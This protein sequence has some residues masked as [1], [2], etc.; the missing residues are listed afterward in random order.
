MPRTLAASGAFAPASRAAVLS[1]T[2]LAASAPGLI[3]PLAAL[4]LLCAALYAGAPAHASPGGISGASGE[5]GD[6]SGCHSGSTYNYSGSLSSSTTMLPSDSI[7][8][9]FSLNRNSGSSAPN[10]GFNASATSG[11]FTAGTGSHVLVAGEVTH[12]APKATSGGNVSWSFDYNSPATVGTVTLYACGNPVVVDSNT[13]NDGPPGCTTRNITVNGTPNAVND[14]GITVAKNSSSNTLSPLSNDTSGPSGNEGGD[15]ITI[16]STG[17]SASSGTVSRINA[18]TQLSYTPE[19]DFTGAVTINYQIVDS[20]GATDSATLSLT[21]NNNAPVADND[22]TYNGTED[23]TLNVSAGSGVLVGDTDAN[24]DSLQAYVLAVPSNGNLTLNTN[25]SFSY[26]PDANTNGADSFTYRAWDGT[27]YSAAAT[28]NISIAAVNDNPVANNDSYSTDEDVPVSGNVRTNDTDAETPTG[29]LTVEKLS[30]PAHGTLTSWTPSTG[31]F[32]YT[33]ASLY[34]GPD[35]FTYRVYDGA[36]YSGTATVNISVASVNNAPVAVANSYST[37]EDTTLNVTTVGTLGNG[38]LANDTDA[39]SPSLTAS[40][41][42]NVSYGSLTLNSNGTFSYTP[43]L[44]YNGPDSFTYRAYDGFD[45]SN[46]VTVS[47][48]VNA[49]NDAPTLSGLPNRTVTETSAMTSIA[50]A[51]VLYFGDVDNVSGFTWSFSGDVPGGMAIDGSTGAVTYTPGEDVVPPSASSIDY[52]VTVQVTDAGSLSAT[53]VFRVTIN[54]LDDDGDL[55]ADYNDNCVYEAN[56]SQADN[57]NDGAD[58]DN[59]SPYDADGGDACDTDDDNDTI[60]D[61]AEL[62][63]GLDPND[64]S[65]AGLDLDG[66][67]LTNAEEFANCDP[68]DTCLAIGTD[69]VGPE[70][71]TNGDITVTATGYYTP[72]EVTATAVDVINGIGTPVAVSV[73]NDG[74]FRPGLHTI[75]WTA[76]DSLGNTTQEEQVITVLP[77]VSLGGSRTVGEGGSSVLTVQLM[78]ESPDYPVVLHYTVSGTAGAA[79]HN[80]ADGTVTIVSGTSADITINA[81]VDGTGEGDET[82]VL[83]LDEVEDGG[84]VLSDALTGTFLIVERNVAPT[85]VLWSEQDGEHRNVVYTDG[86]SVY[87]TALAGDANDDTLSYDWSLTDPD[88]DATIDGDA[89]RFDPSLLSDG[90]MHE[91]VVRVSDGA[92]VTE[93]RIMLTVI[94][95]APELGAVDSDGDGVNDE[96]EGGADSDGDGLLDYL[97]AISAPDQI[98][99]RIDSSDAGLLQVVQVDA[100][101]QIVAGAFATA[102]QNGGVQ[103]LSSAVVNDDDDLV[104]DEDYVA[105]GALYDFLITGLGEADRVANVVLP[106][107]IALPPDAAWRKYINGGWFSFAGTDTDA[108][109]SAA[110][111]DGQCPPPESGAWSPGLTA[112]HTCVRL[113]LSDGGPNDADGVINGVIRDPGGPAVPRDVSDPVAPEAEEGGGSGGMWFLVF[114]ALAGFR[115]GRQRK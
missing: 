9:T 99:L 41:V 32:T 91:V 10:G 6:C 13:T 103:I 28:V 88:L 74:P 70:I 95:E 94:S 4:S 51:D 76:E 63:N 93:Q 57:D 90:D 31:A 62:A 85:V 14:S 5:S 78:G 79:D 112:G 82:V 43:S 49:V 54:K 106:L 34:N 48:T 29:S 30:D 44:N 39:D 77:T 65:D 1:S 60:S 72:V 96:D 81:S 3:R 59:D 18:N 36:L 71:T 111:V 115:S 11:S 24:G 42:A 55:V 19:A 104:I 56:A 33:P 100:G 8:V 52:D 17:L 105:V 114:L 68:E 69:S 113:T 25:G 107:P 53:D 64:D 89:I 83:T 45:Y 75:T 109:A 47:L 110:A 102:A 67:G 2:G 35:S 26:V 61:L 87:V 86:D 12:S 22:G 58:G 66:D 21:V 97:D 38:V 84:A 80:L 50:A 92:L 46:T 7:A 23:T 40:V 16:R 15:S 98:A 108:L 27:A 101:L 73:D 20:Q 37:N